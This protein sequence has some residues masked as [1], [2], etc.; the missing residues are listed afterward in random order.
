MNDRK[1]SIKQRILAL[2][3][4]KGPM[5][6]MDIAAALE[7]TKCS[8]SQSTK[9]MHDAGFIHISEWRVSSKN[10]GNKVY[11]VGPGKDAIRPDPRFTAKHKP[12]E[13]Q[14]KEPFTPHADVAAAWLRNPI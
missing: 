10:G 12:A 7:L 3:R 6:S 13:Q 2:L 14:P 11:A 5:I 9:E 4:V 1:P 8:A